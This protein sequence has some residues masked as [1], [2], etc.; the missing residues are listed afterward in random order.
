MSEHMFRLLRPIFR[1]WCC[2][3]FRVVDRSPNCR[4]L[5]GR[6]AKNNISLSYLTL[7]GEREI[8]YFADL[9]AFLCRQN[10]VDRIVK[11]PLP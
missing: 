5:A 1:S 11:N 10:G 3:P 6:F 9:L 4:D 2:V 8:Y 7:K